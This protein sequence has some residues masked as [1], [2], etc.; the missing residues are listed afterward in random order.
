MAFVRDMQ[1]LNASTPMLVR[2]SPKFTDASDEQPLNDPIPILVTSA[3]R[4]AVERV[5]QFMNA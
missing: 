2:F 4:V 3:P 5:V 1:S